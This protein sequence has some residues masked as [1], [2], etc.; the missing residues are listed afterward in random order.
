MKYVI[1]RYSK[2]G[3]ELP[4]IFPELIE[5]ATYR[6]LPVNERLGTPTIVSAGFLTSD[7]K[8]HGQSVGLGLAS[9]EQDGRI[10]NMA[11]RIGE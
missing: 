11:W 3:I 1:H 9:R 6:T 10:I 8:A 7:G 4:T 2:V 5:H